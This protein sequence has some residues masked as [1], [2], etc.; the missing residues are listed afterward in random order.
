MDEPERTA[1][2]SPGKPRVDKSRNLLDVLAAL[3]DSAKLTQ[4]ELMSLTGLSRGTIATATT[5]LI[6]K[7]LVETVDA[8]PSLHPGP[9]AQLQI[10]DGEALAL[11][12]DIGKR[13]VAAALGTPSK[14]LAEEVEELTKEHKASDV[15]DIAARLVEKVLESRSPSDLVGACIGLA[16][17]VDLIRTQAAP[18]LRLGEWSGVRLVEELRQ[19]LMVSEPAWENAR[20]FLLANDV[21]LAA[22][23]ELKGA[24][25]PTGDSEQEVTLVVK[26]SDGIGGAILV[27][28]KLLTGARGVAAEL[29][30]TPVP[31]PETDREGAKKRPPA[32]CPTCG[33]YCLEIVAGANVL[34]RDAE[35][36]RGADM[37]ESRP[38]QRDTD[39]TISFGSLVETAVTQEGSTERRLL[40]EAAK[41]LGG[42]LGTYVSVL[43]AR[44]VVISSRSFG[45][46][47]KNE[48][49][50][51]LI[52]EDLREGMRTTV[53]PTAF[54][55]AEIVMGK[56]RDA[57]VE[58]GVAA[59]LDEL[60][61]ERMSEKL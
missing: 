57:T 25:Q 21:N 54:E 15:L 10:V 1:R 46:P 53:F 61:I 23:G 37:H 3:R 44:R 31:L 49:A 14:I 12:I 17:P 52:S 33:H 26:W 35:E 59:V 36:A 39:E 9:D 43:N 22:R 55:D 24:A 32:P 45:E 56:R 5:D 48:A 20:R 6:E 2:E 41:A 42:V 13:H 40:K 18:T 58:G 8:A 27:D 28:G 51:R 38:D 60:L 47:P 34:A 29:G 4:R 11:C 19:R 50:L 7:G 16:A 30:H